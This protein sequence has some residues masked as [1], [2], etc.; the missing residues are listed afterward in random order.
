MFSKQRNDFLEKAKQESA[1][2]GNEDFA[3]NLAKFVVN[4][5][6]LFGSVEDEVKLM[7][8]IIIIIFIAFDLF[9]RNLC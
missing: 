4:R 5:P 1:L 2:A 9:E 3:P 8:I 6:D 7:N